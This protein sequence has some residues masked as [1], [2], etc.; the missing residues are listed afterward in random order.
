MDG[1][2][3]FVQKYKESNHKSNQRS[4]ELEPT[5][6]QWTGLGLKLVSPNLS[7][8]VIQQHGIT[9]VTVGDRPV[10]LIVG[11]DEGVL[12]LQCIRERGHLKGDNVG[13]LLHLPA[14]EQSVH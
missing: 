5:R 9:H 6:S 14:V 3:K 8:L 13:C 10:D 2:Q 11:A 12:C 1:L 4:K 7:R